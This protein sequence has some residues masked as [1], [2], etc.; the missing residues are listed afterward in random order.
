MR[1]WRSIFEDMLQISGAFVNTLREGER[2]CSSPHP[3]QAVPLQHKARL[4]QPS[5]GRTIARSKVGETCNIGR[6]LLSR[7][8]NALE[9]RGIRPQPGSAATL[10]SPEF[11]SVPPDKESLALI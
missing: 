4:R 1:S 6:P 11:G 8:L 5:R 9:K 7:S 2:V 3:P 10:H